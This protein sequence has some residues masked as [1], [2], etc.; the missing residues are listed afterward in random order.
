MNAWGLFIVA[1]GGLL[2]ILGLT[3]KAGSVLN[4][5]RVKSGNPTTTKS[6]S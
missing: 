1:V 4:G 6:Y 3:G 5:A 2:L